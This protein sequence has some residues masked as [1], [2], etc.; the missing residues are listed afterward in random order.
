MG[1]LGQNL[2][3][4]SRS[5][6][7]MSVRQPSPVWYGTSLP[8][9]RSP[10]ITVTD[11]SCLTFSMAAAAW[12]THPFFI[13]EISGKGQGL[14]AARAIPRGTLIAAEEPILVL[15][16]RMTPEELSMEVSAA[17]PL[18]L[19]VLLSLPGNNNSLHLTIASRMK[20]MMLISDEVDGL[21]GLFENICKANH[22]CRPNAERS[23]NEWLGRASAQNPPSEL[24]SII[25]S[26]TSSIRRPRHTRARRNHHL[27]PGR[28]WFFY[29]RARSSPRKV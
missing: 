18:A 21:L 22:S 10:T 11:G 14:L 25:N 12:T 7:V 26:L 20:H 2:W 17:D 15:P 29:I 16:D 9:T 24:H 23:W 1:S 3:V 5:T 13:K 8:R 6:H 4:A 19:D 28:R 27:L